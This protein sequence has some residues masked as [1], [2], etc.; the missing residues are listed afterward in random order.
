VVFVDEVG[1]PNVPTHHGRRGR[2]CRAEGA[3]ERYEHKVENDVEHRD[4]KHGIARTF[5]VA[6]H[7]ENVQH[8]P[9]KGIGELPHSQKHEPW[10]GCVSLFHPKEL[11][12]EWAENEDAKENWTR[13]NKVQLCH[14]V[15]Q[16]M[17]TLPLR[18][19]GTDHGCYDC[20]QG[21]LSEG[22]ERSNFEDN[23]VHTH[24]IFWQII[25]QH[26]RIGPTDDQ[27][28]GRG[29]EHGRSQAVELSLPTGGFGLLPFGQVQDVYRSPQEEQPRDT[30]E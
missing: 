2:Y 3:V 8:R 19:H 6:R 25:P 17:Q 18:A 11:N 14:L 4:N 30:Q 15:G 28:Q 1:R 9:C 20:V 27:K 22:D 23:T 7:V 26:E 29:N 5:L 16:F 12:E 10:V 24:T 13:S 21:K